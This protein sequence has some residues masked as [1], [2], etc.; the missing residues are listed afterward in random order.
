MRWPILFVVFLTGC[1]R[2]EY[3]EYTDVP[4]SVTRVIEA[5]DMFAACGS[6]AA[7]CYDPNTG[8]IWLKY[9]LS[10]AVRQCVITHEYRHAA[11]WTH[12]KFPESPLAYNCGDG[13]TMAGSIA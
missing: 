3:W 9:G 12:P 10:P 5:T 4:R 8:L 11:G 7:G 6:N 2:S 1:S 13:T